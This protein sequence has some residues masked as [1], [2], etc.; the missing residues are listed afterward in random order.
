MVG[1]QRWEATDSYCCDL[2][3]IIQYLNE[4]FQKR[5]ASKKSKGRTLV[6]A[7]E[8]H[9]SQLTHA[10]LLNDIYRQMLKNPE[11][12]ATMTNARNHSANANLIVI[13][14]CNLLWSDKILFIV[15]I[16]FPELLVIKQ[17]HRQL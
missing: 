7:V 3:V 12:T 17:A 5:L 2:T 13:I 16:V 4:T 14:V 10:G 15:L 1:L 8:D 9:S 6:F 11:R